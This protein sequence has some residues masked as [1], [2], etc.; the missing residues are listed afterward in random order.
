[1]SVPAADLAPD[2]SP[3]DEP[4]SWSRRRLRR[5]LIGS[6]VALVLVVGLVAATATVIARRF[7]SA[8]TRATLLEPAA[9]APEQV[10]VRG[11]PIAGPL[12]FLL[13]GS[14]FRID[15]P[16]GGQRSDT[17]IVGHVSRAFDQ[18]F[19]LSIPRDLLVRIPPRPDLDFFGDFTKV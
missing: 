17:I 1:M 18:V 11:A 13:L 5:L 9:R 8:V 19:L 3:D 10:P 15:D 16:E 6:A 12:N 7:E 2:P 14:D 4:G